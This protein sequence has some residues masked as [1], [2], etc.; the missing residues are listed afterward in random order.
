MSS[1]E[2]LF[3]IGT[4]EIPA[5]YIGPAL[6]YMASFLEQ[7]LAELGLAFQE[8]QTMGTPRR[9]TV[10]VIGL[11]SRQ[12]DRREECIGP[13][14]KAGFDEAG[15]PTQAALGFARSRGVTVEDLKVVQTDKG[16]YLMAVQEIP[17]RPTLELLAPL[18]TR[19]LETLPFPKS[20]RWARSRLAFARPLQWLLALFG[21]DV[22]PMEIEGIQS[23]NRSRGHRFMAPQWFTVKDLAS[24][25]EELAKRQVIV[26]PVQRR[27]MVEDAVSRAVAERVGNGEG[28][29]FLDPA[30]VETV[31]NLVEIPWGVCGT[32]DEKFLR[33][34]REVLVTSMREHQKYFPVQNEQ[35]QLLPLFVAVN[36][37]GIQD[38]A[39]AASGHERVLRARLEDALFFF[40][41]DRKIPLA[42]RVEQLSGIVFQRRLGTMAEKVARMERLTG[43][44]AERLIPDQANEA[45]RAAHLAKADLLTEMVGEFPSLQGVIGG[46][47]A[48]LDGENN[49]VALA[50]REHYMPVR[51][52][53]D[54]PSEPLGAVVGL[55]DR[56]DT[57]VGCFAIGEKPTGNKDSFGLRRQAI[58]LINLIRGFSFS[59]SL[60]QAAQEALAAY[61]DNLALDQA[62]VDEV[63]DF[64]RLR[65]EN[66]LAGSGIDSGVIEAVTSADFDDLQDCLLRIE[67]LD[68]IREQEIFR[69]LSG[70]F[71]RIRNITRENSGTVVDEPLLR[72]EA[73]QDLYRVV[74]SVRERALPL[75]RDQRYDEALEIMLLIKEP[76]DRFFDEVMVMAEE[77]ELRRNRLNLLTILRDLVL[78]V[79][80]I[81][82]VHGESR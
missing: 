21:P 73:E 57:L 36:N 5:G 77:D 72:E 49:S 24:Y 42:R 20:M 54:L 75:I 74:V 68:R 31:T 39:M 19:L 26:D 41:E 12:R 13:P 79:G 60:R 63:L 14:R 48:R 8:A 76:V 35:G 1:Q 43:W 18:L 50:V 37:T 56:L 15:N 9:L 29:P 10:A 46:E 71:R 4:E 33:L 22:V 80:D 25:R 78:R 3:E 59:L 30:L 55:A 51:A 61:E 45:A 64:V 58:G 28:R 7:E 47:Y 32:F 82:R 52:G 44:L 81:S 38:Q 67:A 23:G 66:E 16:E 11:E 70:S 53:G 2:L 6:E 27:K 65:F 62:V 69:V 40:N 17:G 34:P